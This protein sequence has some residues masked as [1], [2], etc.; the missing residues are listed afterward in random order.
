MFYRIKGTFLLIQVGSSY[1]IKQNPLPVC[2]NGKYI[3]K[4][5]QVKII[6][7]ELEFLSA[8]LKEISSIQYLPKIFEYRS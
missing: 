6:S 2:W 7:E 1:R 3:N 5:K 4:G 8:K